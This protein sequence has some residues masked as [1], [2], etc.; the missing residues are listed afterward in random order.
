MGL[1]GDALA[2]VPEAAGVLDDDAEGLHGEADRGDVPGDLP[3]Q[4]LRLRVPGGAAE[5]RHGPVLGEFEVRGRN[6][7]E[8]QRAVEIGEDGR[9]LLH[10]EE[11]DPVA[12]AADAG[13]GEGEGALPGGP[14]RL[15]DPGDGPLLGA[16]AL[17]RDHDHVGGDLVEERI[18]DA[19]E[20]LDGAGGLRRDGHDH[21]DARLHPK[22]FGGKGG[23]VKG[24]PGRP[25]G[26]GRR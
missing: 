13:E 6:H 10:P 4:E 5:G 11:D 2:E 16:P 3:L 18:V 12:G 17:G 9:P 20:L 25:P 14:H 19:A 26:N 22:Y 1:E 24:G 8:D 7:G 15:Q 21:G 23:G